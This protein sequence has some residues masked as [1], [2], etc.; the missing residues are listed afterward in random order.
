MEKV[1]KVEE[2]EEVEEEWKRVGRRSE[3]GGTV[4]R[5]KEDLQQEGQVSNLP[6][7]N[8]SEVELFLS[9]SG[10]IVDILIVYKLW[11]GSFLQDRKQNPYFSGAIF[12]NHATH[13]CFYN[14]RLTYRGRKENERGH[15]VG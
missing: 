11:S 10:A 14:L 9:G 5:R 7:A 2:V 4:G 15:A 12:S 3:I 13:L 1:E 8:V 6:L